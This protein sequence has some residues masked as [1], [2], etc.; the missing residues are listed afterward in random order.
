MGIVVYLWLTV[1]RLCSPLARDH[2][3][4]CPY[5]QKVWLQ[6]EEKRIPYIIEKINMRCYGDKPPSFMAK[7]PSGLLPVLEI[8]GRTVTESAVIM[9]LL[10]DA[11]PDYKPLMP[12]RGSPER[13]HAEGLMKLER[14]YGGVAL[15]EL[16][17]AMLS[18][19][20]GGARRVAGGGQGGYVFG[21]EGK[22]GQGEGGWQYRSHL[23]A[24][25]DY[26]REREGGR[27][28]G[29]GGGERGEGGRLQESLGAELGYGW[30]GEGVWVGGGVTTVIMQ[31][32]EDAFPDKKPLMPKRVA[33]RGLM[34][35]D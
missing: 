14:R 22:G 34:R 33:L 12:K 6:L 35:R 11:F 18:C 31:L 19:R 10:E 5:C 16:F 7:V 2:A 26:G 28:R 20:G 3:A 8:D 17:G 24:R 27:G 9:Q 15:L 4:W 32:L 13:A 25:L 30:E 23:G 1:F 21:R 29:R